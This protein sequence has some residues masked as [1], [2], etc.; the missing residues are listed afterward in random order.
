ML[1]VVKAECS[2]TESSCLPTCL[3]VCMLA[4]N[5]RLLRDDEARALPRLPRRHRRRTDKALQRKF[6]DE[7]FDMNN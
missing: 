1:S 5:V 4:H 7:Q 3:L 6:C 2:K